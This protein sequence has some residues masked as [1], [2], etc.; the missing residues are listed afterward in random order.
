MSSFHLGHSAGLYLG[1]NP[2]DQRPGESSGTHDFNS[3]TWSEITNVGDTSL[4]GDPETADLT[5]RDSARSGFT[6]E[7][8]VLER[9]QLTFTMSVKDLSSDANLESIVEAKI[10]KT[11]LSLLDLTKVI[12]EAGAWGFVA[13][14]TINFSQNRPVKGGQ[15]INVTA[16]L[17]SYSDYVETD[18]VGSGPL[19]LFGT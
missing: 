19:K 11:E 7:V 5:T 15:I 12:S 18:T 8:D 4:G 2:L 17:V 3:V 10:N 16:K 9:G 1:S 13:N 6:S 14:W